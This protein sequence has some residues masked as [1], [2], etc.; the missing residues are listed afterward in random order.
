MLVQL[1]P[2]WVGQRAT[3][4]RGQGEVRVHC[5]ASS[6]TVRAGP[7]CVVGC[8]PA[9][10]GRSPL[11]GP[12]RSGTQGGQGALHGQMGPP[13]RVVC[14]PAGR[15]RKEHWLGCNP[16]LVVLLV[17]ALVPAGHWV[18][19]QAPSPR[20]C[21]VA[22]RR[23]L[24]LSEVRAFIGPCFFEVGLGFA[25]KPKVP[26]PCRPA[27]SSPWASLPCGGGRWGGIATGSPRRACSGFDI[28]N[29]R[30]FSTETCAQNGSVHGS[31]ALGCVRLG[32]SS[33]HH[34]GVSHGAPSPVAP[35]ALC[36]TA[37]PLQARPLHGRQG[38]DFLTP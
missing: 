27:S 9:S 26:C 22:G 31:P 6:A 33:P 14:G 35:A 21:V 36:V 24:A 1:V 20:S 11:P 23:S 7:P 37:H 13:C 4:F 2:P 8:G 34:W 12:R 19:G 25:A 38:V 16:R 32:E 30:R 18:L 15:G 17:R 3:P 10:K 28:T 29:S 5:P